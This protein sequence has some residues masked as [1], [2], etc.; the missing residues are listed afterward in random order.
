MTEAVKESL[1]RGVSRRG[2]SS[3]QRGSTTKPQSESLS[4]FL[5]HGTRVSRHHVIPVTVV[6]VVGIVVSIAVRKDQRRRG[7]RGSERGRRNG[8]ER[9]DGI[10][11]RWAI[12]FGDAG[13]RRNR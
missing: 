1:R 6:I 8:G 12:G 11:V 7:G 5:H 4:L 10:L 13:R 2:M 9:R 3:S